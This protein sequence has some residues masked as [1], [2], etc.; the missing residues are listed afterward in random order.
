MS[1]LN[2]LIG[3]MYVVGACVCVLGCK[4]SVADGTFEAF[5]QIE[6]VAFVP[7][8]SMP[9]DI[10]QQNISIVCVLIVSICTVHKVQLLNYQYTMLLSL[11][12]SLKPFSQA[13]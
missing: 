7:H 9:L 10:V 1:V 12:L 2:K 11:S 8:E 3:G 13:S 4:W 5:V 6:R